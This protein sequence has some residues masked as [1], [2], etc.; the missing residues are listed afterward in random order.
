LDT[1]YWD[2]TVGCDNLL[3]ACRRAKPRLHVFGHIHEAYGAVRRDW[4]S[5]NNTKIEEEDLEI[6]MENRRRYIDMSSGAEEPFRYGEETLFVN[7]SIVTV[8][9]ET[10]NAPWVVDLDLPVA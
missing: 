7:A 9:Y 5:D 1:T 6:V 3:A 10:D 2:K 8:G 4:S